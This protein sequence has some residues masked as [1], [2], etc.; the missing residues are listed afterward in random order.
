[1][2]NIALAMSKVSKYMSNQRKV[3][4]ETMKWILMYLK[5]T[6]DYG[7]LFDV[8]LDDAKFLLRYVD[9]DYGQDLDQRKFTIGYV[10]T[11]Y[12]GIIS[13]KIYLTEVCSL[14]YNGS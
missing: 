10:F 12:G 13:W 11:L 7:L 3:H 8:S 4:W 6:N 14:V 1:M 5:S 9:D 2:S